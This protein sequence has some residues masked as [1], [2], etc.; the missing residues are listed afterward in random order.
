MEVLSPAAPAA[1][2]GPS[3]LEA[4][5]AE[6]RP[7]SPADARGRGLL[8]PEAALLL[9]RLLVRAARGRGAIEVAVGEGLA[10]LAEGDRSLRLGYGGVGDDARERLG[11]AGRTAQAMVQLARALRDRPL[12]REAVRRGEVSARKA[13]TVLAVARGDA[14]AG[15][16]GRARGESVRALAAGVRAAGA[17]EPEPEEPWESICVGMAPGERAKLDEAMELAGELVGRAA[18]RWQK[19]EAICQE[20][21]GAHPDGGEGN[22]IALHGTVPE[23]WQESVKALFERETECWAFLEEAAPVPA[24][25]LA[26]ATDLLRLDAELRRL[27]SVRRRWDEVFGHVALL[28]RM[29]GLWRDMQFVSFDHYCAERLG[30]GARTVEQRIWLERRLWSLPGLREAMREGRLSYEKARLVARHAEEWTIDAWIEKAERTTCIALRREI[31]A[32]EEGQMCA[33]SDLGLRVPE[34]V[35]LVMDAAIRAARKAE[36]RWI[37]SG[38]GLFR[39]A[40]HFIETWESS[41]RRRSTPQRRAIERDLGLCRVPGC[42]R[43]AAHAHHLTPRSRGGGD[44]PENLVALCAA[45]HLHCVHYGW[46]RVRG[47]APAELR[48]EMPC[49]PVGGF[50]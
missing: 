11:I 26:S 46:I 34:R 6:A 20:Y 27:M 2:A 5:A 9:D 1:R 13:L 37:C 22:G 36:G 25:E 42:S 50:T 39:I 10:A 18:P 7:L 48:W 43:P 40:E 29:T 47:R 16:V 49:P 38:R 17:P 21:L 31:E 33:P 24:P 14:E 4:L 8:R 45:H 32:Q 19:L 30:M 23:P 15:W 41:G 3:G 28:L 44:E 12:L 35:W